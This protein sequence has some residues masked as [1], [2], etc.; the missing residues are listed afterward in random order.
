MCLRSRIPALLLLLLLA[1]ASASFAQVPQSR[2]VYIVA[3]ENRS[4]EHIVGSTDMPFLNGL[5]AQSGLATEFYANQH[6]SLPNYFWLTAGQQV[7]MDDDTNA[8]YDVDN[9]VRRL[10]KAGLSYKSYAQGIPNPGFADM[11]YNAYMKRHAILPWYVDMGGRTG[12]HDAK[13]AHRWLVDLK[14]QMPP[15]MAKHV[16]MN[17]W[18]ADV[19]SGNLPN[20]AFITPDGNH[21]MHNCDTVP[22]SACLQIADQFLKENL[23][24]LLARP[25]FQ[26]G[27]D[28]LL[29]IWADEADLDGID[30]R[31]SA[32]VK[33]GCGGHIV[34][35]VIG[36]N[37]KQGYKS[38][39]TY[40][41]E[42]VLR[43]M[44]DALGLPGPYP[45]AADSV[46]NM[47]EFFKTPIPSPAP[48]PGTPDFAIAPASTTSTN[49]TVAPGQSATYALTANA[50]SGFS[51]SLALTCFD[52]P[53][54][55]TCS[56]DPG[57]VS[58]AGNSANLNV[59][60]TTAPRSSSG[61]PALPFGFA[62]AFAALLL[63]V[64][65]RYTRKIRWSGLSVLALG[66]GI[67]FITGCGGGGKSLAPAP[68]QMPIATSS[69]SG[70]TPVGSYTVTV[71]AT[72]NSGRTRI[73]TLSL[74]VQ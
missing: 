26:P 13:D 3:E 10:M 18:L 28:G 46:S 39:T 49:K 48:P 38:T 4:Y 25:E 68:T 54:G 35:A 42:H 32:T 14:A 74:T 59:V 56:F 24:P 19:A 45:G 51:G 33:T 53:A 71:V 34:V 41:H 52:L 50:I 15:E 67:S 61:I 60:I 72:S 69:Q 37:V 23:A 11:Y 2:H 44:M 22:L 64:P 40:H 73:S 6:S 12:A 66:L 57:S 30:D 5:I 17:Q 62:G 8:T 7:T 63:F 1:L 70:G 21:D 9:I 47:A 65:T 36:P 55:A 58:L 16:D 20:F 27:G 31:C 43:T 29:I